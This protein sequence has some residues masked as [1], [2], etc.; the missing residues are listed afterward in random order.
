MLGC[1]VLRLAILAIV[2]IL[3]IFN[4]VI[5]AILAISGGGSY[6]AYTAGVLKGWTA[7]GMRPQFDVVTGAQKIPGHQAAHDSES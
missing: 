3:V 5:V 2:A 6:G 7:S 1:L 4:R